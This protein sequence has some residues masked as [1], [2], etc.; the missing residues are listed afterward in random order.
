[1]KT[2]LCWKTWWIKYFQMDFPAPTQRLENKPEVRWTSASCQWKVLQKKMSICALTFSSSRHWANCPAEG[3]TLLSPIFSAPAQDS[4]PP[5]CRRAHTCSNGATT[6]SY[7]RGDGTMVTLDMFKLPLV[8][9]KLPPAR[10]NS[11]GCFVLFCCCCFLIRNKSNFNL[12][13]GDVISG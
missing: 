13:L 12:P 4:S 2:C 1:M 3:W 11:I 9:C 10:R 7:C 5:S 8:L 6:A